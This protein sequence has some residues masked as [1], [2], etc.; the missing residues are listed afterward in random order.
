MQTVALG[1]RG[2]APIVASW[3]AAEK[4]IGAMPRAGSTLAV[5]MP[6]GRRRLKAGTKPH[7]AITRS[8]RCGSPTWSGCGEWST[9][10]GKVWIGVRKMF[11]EIED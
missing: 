10:I 9:A 4:N 7:I 11:W 2:L 8:W 6:H 3:N 1:N 5:R